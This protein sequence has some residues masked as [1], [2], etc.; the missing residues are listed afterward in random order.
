MPDMVV[1]GLKIQ[2][3]QL[4]RFLKWHPFTHVEINIQRSEIKLFSQVYMTPKRKNQGLGAGIS[5]PT[6]PVPSMHQANSYEPWQTLVWHFMPKRVKQR[7]FIFKHSSAIFCGLV[8]RHHS[9]PPLFLLSG[10]FP[11]D[12]LFCSFSALY[13]NLCFTALFFIALFIILKQDS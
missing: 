2:E 8:A 6:A 11:P 12:I 9:P 1:I 5:Y 3:S 4:V 10:L 13:L 7:Q